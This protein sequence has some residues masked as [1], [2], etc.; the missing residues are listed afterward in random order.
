MAEVQ[1]GPADLG[2]GEVGAGCREEQGGIDGCLVAGGVEEPPEQ[3]VHRVT[4]PGGAVFLQVLQFTYGDAAGI[5]E[6][7]MGLGPHDAE[8]LHQ[9][10][11]V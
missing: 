7:D 10:V 8:D 2:S 3:G 9:A 4:D 11:L 5:S 1:I 6:T